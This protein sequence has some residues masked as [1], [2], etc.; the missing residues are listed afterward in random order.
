MRAAAASCV[1]VG[2]CSF[3]LLFGHEANDAGFEEQ[4]KLW[5]RAT[6]KLV[7]QA[8]R[9]GHGGTVNRLAFSPDGKVMATAG[10]DGRILLW[11]VSTL[12]TP[13][14]IA[15]AEKK[16]PPAEVTCLAFHPQGKILAAGRGTH[17]DLWDVASRKCLHTL[18]SHSKTVTCIT[19]IGDG[20]LLASGSQDHT[21]KLWETE[22]GEEAHTMKGHTA[23]VTAVVAHA[24]GKTLFSGSNDGTVRVW[25]LVSRKERK[26]LASHG[27][28]ITALAVH[29]EG[30]LLAVGSDD[31]VIELWE[32]GPGKGKSRSWPAHAAPVTAL[33]FDPQGR[34][35][36]SAG[37]DAAIRLWDPA[38]KG[39][40]P[41]LEGHRYRVT[42]LEFSPDGK[43]LASG[44]ERAPAD[45]QSIYILAVGINKYRGGVRGL[46]RARG[47]AEAVAD[48]LATSARGIYLRIEKE[49]LVDGQAT[50]ENVLKA[51]ERAVK[52]TR[53]GDT[54]VFYFA[55]KADEQP[56]PGSTHTE[57]RLLLADNNRPEGVLGARHLKALLSR[58]EPRNQLVILDTNSSEFAFVT[59]VSDM[60]AQRSEITNLWKRN[61]GLFT[62]ETDAVE[63][64]G[65]DH[66]ELTEALLQGL[67]GKADL[68]DPGD[69]RITVRELQAYLHNTILRESRGKRSPRTYF[70][71][72]DFPLV[73]LGQGR[74]GGIRRDLEFF[75]PPPQRFN[76][77]M[78]K[79]YALLVATDHYNDWHPLYNPVND[80]TAV[81][82]EL[83][84][85]YGF[86]TEL[87]QNPELNDIFAALMH[88]AERKYDQD[89]QLFLFFAGHGTYD[90]TT[91][92]GFVVARDSKRE[93]LY[94]NSYLP[95]SRLR[96]IVNNIKCRH[97]FIVLDVC[98][99]GTFD[100]R[101]S[102]RRG[103]EGDAKMPVP[104]F[105]SRKLQHKTRKYLTSGGK[106]YVK[107]GEPGKHSPFAARFLEALRRSDAKDHVLTYHK[108]ISYVENLKPQPRTGDFGAFEAG[109]DFLF[110]S[111]RR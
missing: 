95:H 56:I 49:V 111:K 25:N 21:V 83:E 4:V 52:K 89:D 13:G 12:G 74:G 15:P 106:E 38:G 65:K 40:D 32:E 96:E 101:I 16:E 54:F 26:L 78:G 10:A 7:R 41:G 20:S 100:D 18:T 55:G 14:L 59:L 43:L 8:A 27:A 87:I 45:G 48:T 80:A 85:H 70:A 9:S 3:A 64:E 105:I 76:E 73:D 86:Q 58:L 84:A 94:R 53:V 93:D 103:E 44:G 50:K 1:A 107:D 99:G 75:K 46:R 108:L 28:R 90:D 11:D 22:T 91:G 47:D 29:R 66:G 97:I 23:E 5:D 61:T 81:K 104:Q 69:G 68:G 33:A 36:A 77:R 51:F 2:F 39:L 67:A 34:C 17:I 92:E 30:G 37:W 19:F 71:G 88:Y 98:F 31:G 63:P 82:Q 60:T 57:Y 72:R 35:L 79:D 42:S 110:I 6:G 102:A 62:V 109:S 24:D